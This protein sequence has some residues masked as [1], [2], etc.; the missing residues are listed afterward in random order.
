[1]QLPKDIDQSEARSVI[2]SKTTM[3]SC[4][5]MPIWL[6]IQ[7]CIQRHDIVRGLYPS[8]LKKDCS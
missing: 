8:T 7:V 1:V 5:I 3:A 4:V 6:I 2:N